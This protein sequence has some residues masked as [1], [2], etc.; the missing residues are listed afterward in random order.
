MP[1]HDEAHSGCRASGTMPSPVSTFTVSTPKTCAMRCARQRL[2]RSVIGDNAAALHH[3]DPVGETRGQS[4]VM[5]DGE[6]G[7]AVTRRA[8]QELHH[9]QLV[10]RI[11]RS[12]RLVGEQHRRFGRK[13]ARQRDSRPL[14]AGKRGDAAF[15]ERFD[16]GAFHRAADRGA[17]PA[18]TAWRMGPCADGVQARPPRRPASASKTHALA[19][20]RRWRAPA[21]GSPWL[22]GGAR[23]A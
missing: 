1:G 20:D 19:A 8:A 13:C 23:P 3:Q 12:R 15:G 21:R 22:R 10:T 16:G 5:Q 9:H 18:A 14:A 4:E 2:A 17:D 11:E 6:H 7:P